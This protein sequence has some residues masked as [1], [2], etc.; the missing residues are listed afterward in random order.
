MNKS[1]QLKV[2][3]QV[4]DWGLLN[5]HFQESSTTTTTTTTSTATPVDSSST[6]TSLLM[7]FLGDLVPYFQTG[8]EDSDA[9]SSVTVT[10]SNRY[11]GTSDD[12]EDSTRVRVPR[13]RIKKQQRE[14]ESD[15][16]DEVVRSK[17][18]PLQIRRFGLPDEGHRV[19]LVSD[20]D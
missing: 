7:S 12:R 17:K 20:A 15:Q 5:T 16:E 11:S 3:L 4:Q 19:R 9:S 8:E 6:E 13:V 10:D 18:I 14:G 1:V 2:K